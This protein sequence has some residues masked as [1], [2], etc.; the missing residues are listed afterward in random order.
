VLSYVFLSK[1][2]C[3]GVADA[4][5]M[6]PFT[7]SIPSLLAPTVFWWAVALNP[8]GARHRLMSVKDD[9]AP[10][11]EVACCLELRG[12]FNIRE[13][14]NDPACRSEDYLKVL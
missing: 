13:D 2:C 8:H 9:T 4:G 3:K 14:G 10:L 6:A 5:F 7:A 11:K 12:A 1:P